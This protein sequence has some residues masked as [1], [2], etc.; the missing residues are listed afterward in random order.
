MEAIALNGNF[1]V[2][3]LRHVGQLCRRTQSFVC[4][5]GLDHHDPTD[6]KTC[7]L[8]VLLGGDHLATLMTLTLP[9]I[10]IY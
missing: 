1:E 9:F 3:Y 6:R 7:I 2:H 10:V 4:D 8:L 5:V